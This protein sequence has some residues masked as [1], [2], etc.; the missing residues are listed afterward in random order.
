MEDIPKNIE[1]GKLKYLTTVLLDMLLAGC[2]SLCN[3]AKTVFT[4]LN[5]AFWGVLG[6]RPINS[7]NYLVYINLFLFF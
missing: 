6:F 5:N 7:I 4:V 3:G 2:Y 1:C